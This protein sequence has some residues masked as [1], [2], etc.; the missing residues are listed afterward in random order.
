M[1]NYPTICVS[2]N[3]ASYQVSL[4]ATSGFPLEIDIFTKEPQPF[5]QL[6]SRAKVVTVENIAIHIASIDD[7]IN[8]KRQVGRAHDLED[9]KALELI[10]TNVK[11]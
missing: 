10:R 9:I 2:T 3:Q 1:T 6:Y 7:I 11:D 8:M 4:Y 5:M